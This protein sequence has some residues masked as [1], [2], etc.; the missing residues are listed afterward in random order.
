MLDDQLFI[1]VLCMSGETFPEGT[2]LT[3]KE[4]TY[5]PYFVPQ[6]GNKLVHVQVTS[7]P[8]P[9]DRPVSANSY[10]DENAYRRVALDMPEDVARGLY[11]GLHPRTVNAALGSVL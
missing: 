8:R 10:L 3:V 11:H 5:K 4:S 9:A 1:E 7:V 2:V 6:P